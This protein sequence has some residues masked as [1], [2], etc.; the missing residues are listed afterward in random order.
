MD[1][2]LEQ[3]TQELQ[4]FLESL[5]GSRNVYYNP[6]ASLRMRYP[7]IVYSRS[8]IENQF[9]SDGVYMQSHRYEL[10]VVTDDADA[11]IIQTVSRLPKCSY[12]R[13]FV[14]DNLHHTVFTLYF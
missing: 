6:P 5:L 9:A 13:H 4:S 1:K 10:T 11:E 8:K 12:N 3:R 7:A 2:S 14:S